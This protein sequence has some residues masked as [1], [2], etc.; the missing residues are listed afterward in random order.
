[1]YVAAEDAEDAYPRE[2][3]G[4]FR[5]FVEL[6]LR[7]NGKFMCGALASNR[8]DSSY[9][10]V[11]TG[12][13]DHDVGEEIRFVFNVTRSEESSACCPKSDWAD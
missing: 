13:D 8:S 11:M 6:C 4:S 3:C 7:L 2:E 9:D 12:D 1:V 10:V 5:L